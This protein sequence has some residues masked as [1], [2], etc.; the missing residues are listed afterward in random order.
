MVKKLLLGLMNL[1]EKIGNGRG[2]KKRKE[3]K[4][5]YP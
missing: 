4:V 1:P 3:E 5:A 2:R